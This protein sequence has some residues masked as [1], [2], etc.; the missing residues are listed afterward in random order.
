MEQNVKEK[1]ESLEVPTG[2]WV[3][4]NGARPPNMPAVKALLKLLW[5][6]DAA[7][8]DQI[9]QDQE[10]MLELKERKLNGGSE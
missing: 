3:S 7:L 5:G 1:L 9:Q 4:H 8:G 10:K 2:T 6:L